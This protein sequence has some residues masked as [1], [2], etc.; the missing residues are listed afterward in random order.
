MQ[1]Y[2]TLI[3]LYTRSLK[4]AHLAP[5]FRLHNI[6]F[7]S[8]P[9][10]KNLNGYCVLKNLFETFALKISGIQNKSDFFTRNFSLK[11]LLFAQNQI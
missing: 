11:E 2:F 3:Y 1:R 4:Y 7:N 8:L 5:V 6:H 9:A 10:H